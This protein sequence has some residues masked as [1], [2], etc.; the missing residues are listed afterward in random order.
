VLHEVIDG[1]GVIFQLD[2]FNI[3][4]A[5]FIPFF[6]IKSEFQDFSVENINA[7]YFDGKAGK[8]I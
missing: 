6:I 2:V 7:G 5:I 3:K 8:L 4:T 1:L